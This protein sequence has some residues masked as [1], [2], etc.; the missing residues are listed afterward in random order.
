ME[1]L[2]RLVE[3]LRQEVILHPTYLD[4]ENRLGLVL[5][6]CG[7][8][9]EA[10]VHYEKAL[11]ANPG[12]TNCM[13]NHAFARAAVG[14]AQEGLRTM[15]R[16]V[17]GS[18]GDYALLAAQGQYQ[19]AYGEP[20]EAVNSFERALHAR[21]D[22]RSAHHNLAVSLL[23]LSSPN[24]KRAEKLFH[25]AGRGEGFKR[26][27]KEIGLFESGKLVLSEQAMAALKKPLTQ[28][29]NSIRIHI[30][31][32]NLMASEGDY[33]GAKREFSLSLGLAPESAEVENAFG[34]VEARRGNT[35][36]AITHFK[37][38]VSFDRKHVMAHANLAFIYGEKG[39]LRNALT[40]MRAAVALAPNYADLR[41]QLGTLLIEFKK[42]DEAIE[43][44][45]AA[46]SLNP[47]YTFAY[48]RLASS[49][50]YAGKFS[51]AILIYRKILPPEVELP[52]IHRQL[53]VCYLKTGR[54][55]EALRE[56]KAGYPD[57]KKRASFHLYLAQAHYAKGD[58][59]KARNE[60][61]NYF[62]LKK[63]KEGHKEARRLLAQLAHKSH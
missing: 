59:K 58:K 56:C 18:P 39:Q 32:A 11:K 15:K 45:K 47:N 57:E 31:L 16:A 43:N 20:E 17:S 3:F 5:A 52:D 51:D 50:Y 44:F 28:N 21:P 24:L 42:F 22:L 40:E 53:A 38:A 7:D 27:Y 25:H 37:K 61:R 2:R 55:N 6:F 49:L 34:E 36:A 48:Y 26:Y 54:I 41:Y 13:T 10:I 23:F 62:K 8:C 12:Y 1:A 19:L 30:D 29:P 63:G 60:L 35:P 9:E 33:E 4:I 14:N 46:V